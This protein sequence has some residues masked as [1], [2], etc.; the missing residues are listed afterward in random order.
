MND[1]KYPIPNIKD[2]IA[3]GD[4]LIL[5]NANLV[6]REPEEVKRT[7]KERL[8]TFPWRPW[9]NTKIEP[10]DRPSKEIIRHGNRLIMHPIVYEELKR[11]RDEVTGESKLEFLRN[12]R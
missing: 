10:V 9:E 5:V 11:Q 6:T 8:T 2:A 3:F 12:L 1:H 7:W 4:F